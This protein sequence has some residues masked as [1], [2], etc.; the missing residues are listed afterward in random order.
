VGGLEFLID[1]YLDLLLLG[2][3]ESVPLIN[4]DRREDLIGLKDGYLAEVLI[5]NIYELNRAKELILANVNPKIALELMTQKMRK[6]CL[7]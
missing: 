2:E 5:T 4:V 6:R 3:G 7:R 1:W